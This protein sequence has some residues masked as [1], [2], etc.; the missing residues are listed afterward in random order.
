VRAAGVLAKGRMFD[1]PGVDL[2]SYPAI[3]SL[4]SYGP[5]NNNSHAYI[6]NLFFLS[7]VCWWFLNSNVQVHF[8]FSLCK[9]YGV[10]NS[11]ASGFSK[12]HGFPCQLPLHRCS[13]LHMLPEANTTGLFGA[14]VWRDSKPAPL[15][16]VQHLTV[17]H[18]DFPFTS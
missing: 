2:V 16:Q 13:I 11:T 12:H 1:M 18:L 17:Y 15:L 5:K 6:S 8:R 9:V 14:A 7:V 4:C 3:P 10:E